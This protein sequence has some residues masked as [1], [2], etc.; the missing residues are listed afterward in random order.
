MTAIRF[1]S[2]LTFIGPMGLVKVTRLPLIRLGNDWLDDTVPPRSVLM[3]HNGRPRHAVTLPGHGKGIRP[4]NW[5]KTY[6]PE[7]LTSEEMLRLLS[8]IVTSTP[9]GKP[10]AIGLRNVALLTL[11]WRTG[12]R[13]SEALDLLPHHVEHQARRV[14]VLRGKGSKR[15]TVGIDAGALTALGPWLIERGRLGIPGTAPL[16]C[17]VQHPGRGNRIHSAYVRD[18]L[19]KYA[20]LAE[21]PKR[22]HPHGLRHTLAVSLIRERF[23]LAHVQAQLGHS[24]MAT[25]CIYLRGLGA[26]EAFEAVAER[27]WPGGAS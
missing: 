9:T 5:Q 21:I 13:V 14:T 7:P 25:T 3:G 8:M 27:E 16:F 18:V 4:A 23:S 22:V 12:L 11:L 17:T 26:D 20:R 6:P 10:D 19:H 24:D 15:R 2:E 1:G